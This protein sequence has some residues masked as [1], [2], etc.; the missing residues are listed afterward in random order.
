M[1]PGEH[2]KARLKAYQRCLDALGDPE[3]QASHADR[4]ETR[5]IRG[6][7]ERERD[8]FID[9]IERE[10]EAVVKGDIIL[11]PTGFPE[12]VMIR[13]PFH[14]SYKEEVFALHPMKGVI[15]IQLDHL[16]SEHEHSLIYHYTEVDI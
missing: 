12:G 14:K 9:A 13:K 1:I 8:R 16:K 2:Q 7:I 10:S 6:R 15:L 11:T 3:E 4:V 5:L